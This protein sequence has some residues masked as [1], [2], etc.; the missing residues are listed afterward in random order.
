MNNNKMK[1]NEINQLT[2]KDLY[3]HHFSKYYDDEI[4]DNSLIL[5]E[6]RE[7]ND[8]NNEIT[9]KYIKIT[10]NIE[11]VRLLD[12]EDISKNKNLNNI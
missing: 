8:E 2:I 5:L 6:L 11:K 10:Q 4:N 1:Y 7:E 12:I 9:S 3:L